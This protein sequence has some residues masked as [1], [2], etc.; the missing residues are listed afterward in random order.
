MSALTI[1][2]DIPTNINSVEELVAWSVLLA[3]YLN[4]GIQVLEVAGESPQPVAQF[5]LAK[6]A[7]DTTRLIARVSVKID[8][9]YVNDRT[10]KLWEHAME[11][12]TAAIPSN[13]KAN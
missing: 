5:S 13:F 4:G 6:A 3:A 9:N 12:S 2:A 10:K 11:W 8:P 1:G 7:D